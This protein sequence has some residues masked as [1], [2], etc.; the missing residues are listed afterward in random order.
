MVKIPGIP[1]MIAEFNHQNLPPVT[2]L[3]ILETYC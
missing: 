1:E 3:A 2:K